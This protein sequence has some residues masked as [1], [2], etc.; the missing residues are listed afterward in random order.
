MKMEKLKFSSEHSS[1]YIRSRMCSSSALPAPPALLDA[2]LQH[3][4]LRPVSTRRAEPAQ[5]RS[6][7]G[8]RRDARG[9]SLRAGAPESKRNAVAAAPAPRPHLV[10]TNKPIN[11]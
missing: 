7:S 11:D 4:R 5:P 3:A 2:N 8:T 1:P 9:I 10:V 6:G